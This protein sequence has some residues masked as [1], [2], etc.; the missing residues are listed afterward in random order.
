MSWTQRNRVL[1]EPVYQKILKLPF[2]KELIAGTLSGERFAFYIKQDAYYL[3]YFGKAL[4]VIAAR[5]PKQEHALQFLR[6]AEGAIEVERALHAGYIQQLAISPTIELSP[7]ADY[8]TAFLMQQVYSEPL[9]VAI[10]A[11][12]PCFWIYKE[13]GNYVYAHAELEGHPFREWIATYASEDFGQSVAKALH[14]A[15]ELA[16]ET[17]D[18][19]RAQMTASYIKACQLEWLFWD[20]AYR[21][22]Q[23][24]LGVCQN[25]LFVPAQK[26]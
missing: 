9:E 22:E 16:L 5:L 2:I 17:T 20:S 19:V 25:G 15:N 14:I 3:L 8:Y 10:A 4:S 18:N 13:V 6:F 7:S 26:Q 24:D 12:L 11:I 21:L 1:A 23:W